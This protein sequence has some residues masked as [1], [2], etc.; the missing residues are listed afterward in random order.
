MVDMTYDRLVALLVG[1]FEVDRDVIRPD[2]TF[3]QLG[4]DSLFLVEIVLA[5][6]TETQIDIDEDALSGSDTIERAVEV[7]RD[8]AAAAASSS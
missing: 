5:V 3:E 8:H 4:V 2:I 7:I 1:R 6:Q